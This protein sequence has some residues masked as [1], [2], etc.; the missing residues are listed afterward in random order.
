MSAP[1]F[2]TADIPTVFDPTLYI[3]EMRQAGATL[4]PERTV[5][6]DGSAVQ[7]GFYITGP[8]RM[9]I[10]RAASAINE[11]WDDAIERTPGAL[12]AVYCALVA[13]GER[14]RLRIGDGW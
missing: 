14:C 11:K 8:R 6:M 12:E 1:G 5:P 9:P 3:A 4:V 7:R 2:S 10:S 13:A